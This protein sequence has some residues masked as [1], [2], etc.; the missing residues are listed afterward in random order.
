M[1]AVK[2][3]DDGHLACPHCGGDYLHHDC[4]QIFETGETIHG[5]LHVTVRGGDRPSNCKRSPSVVI[6]HDVRGNPSERR[7]GLRIE[8]W[9][10]ECG[11]S[12]CELVIAQRKGNTE[13]ELIPIANGK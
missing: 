2:I 5:S 3:N 11:G 1:Q 13:I 6:D 7:Q 8:F 4:V 9:C 10:E 12:R